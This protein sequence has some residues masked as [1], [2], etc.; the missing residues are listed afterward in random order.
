[1]SDF[2]ILNFFLCFHNIIW[3]S[4]STIGK[5]HTMEI[6]LNNRS[7]NKTMSI[8]FYE[9]YLTNFQDL[10]RLNFTL[11]LTHILLK[12][13][14]TS[15]LVLDQSL[16]FKRTHF[17]NCTLEIHFS[18]LKG[19][20]IDSNPFDSIVADNRSRINMKIYR[21]KFNLYS[22]DILIKHCNS[23]LKYQS[24]FSDFKLKS[25]ILLSNVYY[26]YRICPLVFNS[27]KL[28]I[29]T[30]YSFFSFLQNNNLEFSKLKSNELVNFKK[31]I[32]KNLIFFIFYID[33]NTGLTSENLFYFTESITLKGIIGLID[34]NFLTKFKNLKF[35]QIQTCLMKKFFHQNN[36]WMLNLNFN[37]NK[38][39]DLVHT[40]KN[41]SGNSFNLIFSMDYSIKIDESWDFYNFSDEDF[42]Y[43]QYYPNNRNIN[44]Y[45]EYFPRQHFQCSCTIIWL[46]QS[47][48]QPW[49]YNCPS[50][51]FCCLNK[52]LKQSIIECKFDYKL[53]KCNKTFSIEKF[54]FDFYYIS[55]IS[56][57]LFDV[58]ALYL[59]P[60]FSLFGLLF[61][62][63][64]LLVL[65]LDKNNKK[66]NTT[67]YKY[68]EFNA[69]FNSLRCLIVPLKL[70][71]ICL[72]IESYFCSSLN[73]FFIS[74]H[75]F[76]MIEYL[77]YMLKTCSEITGISISY[78]RYMM[79]CLN[80]NQSRLLANTKVKSIFIK[81]KKN[82][83]KY[84]VLL[85]SIGFLIATFK[86]FQYKVN[87]DYYFSELPMFPIDLNIA[88]FCSNIYHKGCIFIYFFYYFNT[89]LTEAFFILSSIILDVLLYMDVRKLNKY[90]FRLK[91]INQITTVTS[92]LY[93]M[94][95]KCKKMNKQKEKKISTMIL[96]YTLIYFL[97]RLPQTFLFITNKINTSI[98]LYCSIWFN[99]QKYYEI[100]EI[101]FI[102]TYILQFFILN[103]FN[104]EFRK[105]LRSLFSRKIKQF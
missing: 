26:P 91:F 30:F 62:W 42:C 18:F 105:S 81:Q 67:F 69:I 21:S 51:F 13:A 9:R 60:V 84:L 72:S 6:V 93:S 56:E 15:F 83:K 27:S 11:S 89:V 12:L 54:S 28:D 76:I 33:L 22:N 55:I 74:Q 92:A 63:L 45:L 35:F 3:C 73:S 52:T 58:S 48:K 96:C 46:I 75:T 79:I 25:L 103:H 66:F 47:H 7:L 87:N 32:I 23:S 36:K 80:Y 57:V 70:F 29:L 90:S 102:L 104:R 44:L 94:K 16:S 97:S 88:N 37:S 49:F 64:I 99:C 82:L 31:P 77:S 20:S 50:L 14:P 1:M 38:S 65:R 43:F 41:H 53:Q 19:F 24:I 95:I 78:S 61:N 17:T 39:E 68:I 10:D 86:L 2:K 100:T 4:L 98:D 8:N 40:I 101:F 34:E 71:N 85:L 59:K 5:N